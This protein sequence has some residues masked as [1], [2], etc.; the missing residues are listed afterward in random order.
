V[1]V[2]FQPH[3]YSR[4]VHLAP[5]LARSLAAADVACVTDIYPAREDPLP[6]VS[7]KLVV[8][9]LVEVR[10]GMRVGWAPRLSDAAELLA[11]EA[12]SG[13]LVLTVGAGDVDSTLPLLEELLGR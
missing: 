5:E 8:D 12:R 11:G 10:P 9:R 13:D 3:L 7:G 4:T 1:L 2:L 6:G